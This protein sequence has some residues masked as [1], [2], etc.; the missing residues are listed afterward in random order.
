MKI[1]KSRNNWTYEDCLTEAKKYTTTTDFMKFSKSAYIV[2]KENNWLKDY[3][4]IQPKRKGANIWTKSKCRAEARKYKTATEFARCSRGAFATAKEKGWLDSYTWLKMNS[5]V[6]WT[7]E[8][9]EEV[10][11]KYDVKADFAKNAS[12]A[13]Q[14]ALK[15][16]IL[17]NFTWLKPREHGCK[18]AKWTRDVCMKEASKYVTMIDFRTKKPRAYNAMARNGWLKDCHWL[19]RRVSPQLKKKQVKRAQVRQLTL[20]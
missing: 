16:G 4:W 20:F 5:K 6:H 8:L 2:A 18:K 11:R 15:S 14:Y 3:D 12:G 13:Y 9:C 10:A 7:D 17:G 19:Q 1:R